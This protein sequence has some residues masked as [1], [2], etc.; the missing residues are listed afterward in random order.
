[1]TSRTAVCLA[2]VAVV[3]VFASASPL[4]AQSTCPFTVQGS[5]V[6]GDPDMSP[7]LFRDDPQSTCA[8]PTTCAT[9]PGTFNYDV[10]LMTTSPG[11]T[12][13]CVSVTVTPGPTCTGTGFIH[14]GAY[15]GTFNPTGGCAGW[16]AD[17]GASPDPAVG[18][19][20]YSF[21][22]PP[23]TVFSV[24]VNESFAN[25]LCPQYQV[26]IDGC[27]NTPAD[28]MDFHIDFPR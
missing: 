2:A 5:L 18:P 10:Y 17:I 28:L 15:M 24:V 23:S 4:L 14:S 9:S 6:A 7:R 1:M 11:P 8:A 25:G 21:T 20:T 26:D 27:Q 22:L 13:A 12:A 3:A 16:I 19:K